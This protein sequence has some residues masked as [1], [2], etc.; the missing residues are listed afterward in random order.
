MWVQFSLVF[1]LARFATA[2]VIGGA[3]FMMLPIYEKYLCFNAEMI[4]I[5]LAFNVI[6]DP[7]ITC[8]NVL[9]NGALCQMFEKV[10]NNR[11]I[12]RRVQL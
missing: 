9:A 4:A 8:S 10:L 3:I 11:L 1:V 12:A 2:A 5:L 6:L 7:I